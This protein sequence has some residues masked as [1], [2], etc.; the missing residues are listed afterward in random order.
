M[1]SR[2]VKKK[3]EEEQFAPTSRR[4]QA[5]VRAMLE[6]PQPKPQ[7]KPNLSNS[8]KETLNKPL[9][10]KSEIPNTSALDPTIG[11]PKNT[12]TKLDPLTSTTRAV[13]IVGNTIDTTPAK[14]EQVAAKTVLPEKPKTTNTRVVYEYNPVTKQREKKVIN[15][16]TSEP[17][18]PTVDYKEPTR[19]K[20]E[21]DAQFEERKQRTLEESK[22]LAAAGLTSADKEKAILKQADDLNKWRD[23]NMLTYEEVQASLEDK[24][25]REERMKKV[26]LGN[27]NSFTIT[28]EELAAYEK[29]YNSTTSKILRGLTKAADVIVDIAPIVGGAAGT[30]LAQIYKSYAPEGSQYYSDKSFGDKTVD[31]ITEMSKDKAKDIALGSLKTV[32]NAIQQGVKGYRRVGKGSGN[33]IERAIVPTQGASKIKGGQAFPEGSNIR[34]TPAVPTPTVPTPQPLKSG[35]KLQ[36]PAKPKVEQPVKVQPLPKPKPQQ[37]Q[38]LQAPRTDVLISRRPPRPPPRGIRK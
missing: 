12:V 33:I 17:T 28:D 37:P 4:R 27:V 10:S 18:A 11:K 22:R 23:E 13:D 25:Q 8:I 16:N 21:T 7:P 32:G 30:A 6:A 1:A 14:V 5:Q 20:N 24:R 38:R 34:G 9:I 35:T 29:D 36:L 31:L 19:L 26:G 15:V 2:L 3:K